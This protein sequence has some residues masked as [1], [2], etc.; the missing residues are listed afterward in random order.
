MAEFVERF[1][2][3]G[4][5]HVSDEDLLI[6]QELGI[7]GQPSWAYINDDGTVEV[8]RGSLGE[9]GIIAKMNELAA[10]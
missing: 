10:A 2:V 5:D 4:I 3:E 9:E 6:W 8:E 7:T 1:G